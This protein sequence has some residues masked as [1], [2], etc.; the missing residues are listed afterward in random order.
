MAKLFVDWCVPVKAA[1]F[2]DAISTAKCILRHFDLTRPTI[3][4]GDDE[5][6]IVG[7]YLYEKWDDNGIAPMYVIWAPMPKENK[8]AVFDKAADWNSVWLTE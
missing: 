7:I 6:E 1:S 4:I 3:C 2:E 5:G 8:A